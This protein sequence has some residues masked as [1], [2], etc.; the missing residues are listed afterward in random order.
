MYAYTLKLR[1][2]LKIINIICD[3]QKSHIKYI[4]NITSGMFLDCHIYNNLQIRTAA[5][6]L[7][8]YP[9]KK[10]EA[11]FTDKQLPFYQDRSITLI[12]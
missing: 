1:G 10:T 7:K 11:H 4:I 8:I 5:T 3:Q 2:Y 9:A 6:S 12:T